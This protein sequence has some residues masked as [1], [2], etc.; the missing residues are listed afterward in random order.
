MCPPW[1][2]GD[3]NLSPNHMLPRLASHTFCLNDKA[4]LF[5][6]FLTLM[7]VCV[8][9]NPQG[10]DQESFTQIGVAQNVKA[11]GQ[12]CARA[13]L[14]GRTHAHA[15][16]TGSD[17]VQVVRGRDQQAS[18]GGVAFRPGASHHSL[19]AVCNLSENNSHHRD[20]CYNDV[21]ALCNCICHHPSFGNVY[22]MD[23]HTICHSVD[24]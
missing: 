9:L 18:Q 3:A 10:I 24:L 13:A 6:P 2:T 7:Q 23:P 19:F 12:S 4:F 22:H 16:L 21:Q 8:G 1:G 5:G 15:S 17:D 11:H 20:S 14:P